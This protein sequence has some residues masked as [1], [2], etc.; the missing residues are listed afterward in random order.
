MSDREKEMV[1]TLFAELRTAEQQ[2]TCGD[3]AAQRYQKIHRNRF[4][5]TFEICQRLVQNPQAQVLDV[6][7]SYLTELLAQKYENVS[8]LGLDIQ[9]DDGGQRETSTITNERPHITFD[10]NHSPF[11]NR[12]PKVHQ[13]FDLI[14]YA[15]TIEHLPIA[16][17]YSLA[18]L[19]TLLAE[20]GILLITTPN[21]AMIMKRL[22]L[23]IKGKN[24][25]ERF[26]LF[27]ENPGHYREYTM[28]ELRNYGARCNF[29]IIHAEYINFYHSTNIFYAFMKNLRPSFKDS[30]VVAFRRQKT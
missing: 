6:G 23:L 13:S 5:K 16:P 7:P 10:L 2:Q 15:E 24:P 19:G 22:L 8:T 29:E 27:T 26:R 25:Y 1:K 4:H 9:S 28:N 21:A 30:L 14:V 11:P 3:Q 20:N 18:F 17:E 12:W